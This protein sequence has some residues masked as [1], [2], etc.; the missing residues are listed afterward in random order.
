MRDARLVLA[1]QLPG[2][3]RDQMSHMASLCILRVPVAASSIDG[4]DVLRD[5]PNYASNCLFPADGG[6]A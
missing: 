5:R 2:G 6:R 1:L 4:S 3:N